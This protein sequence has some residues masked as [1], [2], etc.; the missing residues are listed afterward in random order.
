MPIPLYN[1]DDGVPLTSTST[2]TF[3]KFRKKNLAIAGALSVTLIVIIAATTGTS[4]PTTPSRSTDA[5]TT[6]LIPEKVGLFGVDESF[7]PCNDFYNY[8]CNK[9]AVDTPLAH[10]ESY[11]SY[12]FHTLFLKNERELSKLLSPDRSTGYFPQL[13]EFF[14]SCM[15]EGTLDTVGLQPLLTAVDEMLSAGSVEST[16][17]WMHR[18]QFGALFSTYVTQSPVNSSLPV[19]SLGTGGLGLPSK[20][21][22]EADARNSSRVVA[23]LNHLD[24]LAKLLVTHGNAQVRSIFAGLDNVANDVLDLESRLGVEQWSPEES[25]DPQHV[26]DAIGFAGVDARTTS[27]DWSAYAS[28]VGIDTSLPSVQQLVL[29]EPRTMLD[30]LQSVLVDYA[31]PTA[32]HN[33]IFK[34]YLVLHMTSALAPFV[35]APFRDEYLRYSN[36]V[37]GRTEDLSRFY[38]CLGWLENSPLGMVLSQ[39]YVLRHF[40]HDQRAAAEDLVERVQAAFGKR[41]DNSAWL[42]EQSRAGAREKLTKMTNHIGFPDVWP[43]AEG[44]A[45]LRSDSLLANVM[46]VRVFQTTEAHAELGKPVD[47]GKWYMLPHEVNAYYDPLINS[48]FFP[49]GI[50]QAPFFEVSRPTAA[51]YGGIGAVVGHENCHAFDDEGSQF[52][53]DGRIRQWWSNQ[54]R[55]DFEERISCVADLYQTFASVCPST[56]CETTGE[57]EKMSFQ[58]NPKLTMGENLADVGGLQAVYDAYQAHKEEDHRFRI[59]EARRA[60]EA[61]FDSAEQV[62]FTSYAQSWCYKARP[63]MIEQLTRNDPHS[64]DAFRVQGTLSQLPAFAQAFNCKAGDTYVMEEPCSVW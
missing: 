11:I 26:Y 57:H 53:A 64:P 4:T 16:V 28:A 62:L 25:R 13:S 10:N 3:P 31:E 18:H 12:S 17:A 33:R 21:Y 9:W 22:Y 42:D 60:H 39:L 24:S 7:N 58:V 63:E 32:P 35:T 44:L 37:H 2:R 41:L 46:A 29:H 20:S 1:D 6:P 23:Y 34:A 61:G 49:A 55:A 47:Q 51:N 52:D 59:E 40:S 43:S 50:L 19:L 38:Y 36:V 30:A 15:D 56:Y 48:I 14:S 5:S 8:A 27:F 54:S 45:L